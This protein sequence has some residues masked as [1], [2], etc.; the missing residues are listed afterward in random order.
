MAFSHSEAELL[1]RPAPVR[2]EYTLSRSRWE[3]VYL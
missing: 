3:V 1:E 2:I